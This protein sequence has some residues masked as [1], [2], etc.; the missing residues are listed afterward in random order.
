MSDCLANQAPF[1]F[2]TTQ[3][4]TQ[5]QIDER[6]FNGKPIGFKLVWTEVDTVINEEIRLSANEQE[7]KKS[8]E[9]DDE[10]EGTDLTHCTQFACRGGDYCL[11]DGRNICATR[12]QLCIDKSLVCNNR[13]NCA[14]N[15]ESDE[16]NCALLCLNCATNTRARAVSSSSS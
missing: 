15:D 1:S 3:R 9:K 8:K 4:P 14:E 6:H 11:D 16:E 7:A 12:R 5:S 13:P 10:D 2:V